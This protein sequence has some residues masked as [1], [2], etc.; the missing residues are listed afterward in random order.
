MDQEND[1][2]PPRVFPPGEGTPADPPPAAP[3]TSESVNPAVGTPHTPA[4]KT[5]PPI[6]HSAGDAHPGESNPAARVT[7]PDGAPAVDTAAFLA[8]REDAEE[9]IRAQAERRAPGETAAE[10]AEDVAE[11]PAVYL[12]P[13]ETYTTLGLN[14][15]AEPDLAPR[16]VVKA[17]EYAEAIGRV[18]RQAHHDEEAIP[19]SPPMRNTPT[20]P[21][22]NHPAPASGS[23]T[24]V[25][26][27]LEA[28]QS[29]VHALQEI[30][31]PAADIAI[32]AR[33]LGDYS[34]TGAETDEVVP[35]GEGSYRR[36]TTELPNEEE[37]PSTIMAETPEMPADAPV[38]G[39]PPVTAGDRGGL[40]RDE[41]LVSRIDRPAD[42]EIYSDFARSDAD[43][44]TVEQEGRAQTGEA[45][46]STAPD[47]GLGSDGALV[48]VRTDAR[49]RDAVTVSLRSHGAQRVQ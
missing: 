13:N 36:S 23:V 16:M 9:A 37:L 17:S 26:A 42:A 22:A 41:G 40:A 8:A 34:P 19:N 20:P 48:T 11:M 10:E 33:R 27:T 15:E 3:A 1:R 32:T 5:P 45:A 25:F 43:R 28:A 29:A 47:T 21:P 31:V 38:P 12:S 39:A 7:R 24:A 6:I 2:Q 30:G 14:D 49:T 18:E 46:A 44:R 4:L 35:A